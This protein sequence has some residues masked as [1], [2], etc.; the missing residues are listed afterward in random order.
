MNNNKSNDDLIYLEL[1]SCPI[2]LEN[3]IIVGEY[4]LDGTGTLFSI[5]INKEHRQQG[6]AK[7]VITELY[8]DGTITG[9]SEHLF[10]RHILKIW[11]ELGHYP[12][13]SEEDLKVGDI[14]MD[15]TIDFRQ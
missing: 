7:R 5:Q 3:G 1:E 9:P 6:H 2:V 11:N 10:N 12:E 14:A 15:L 4:T 8:K 13:V